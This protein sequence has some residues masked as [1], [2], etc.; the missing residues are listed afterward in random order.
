MDMHTVFSFLYSASLNP[1]LDLGRR[2]LV[3]ELLIV[4]RAVAAGGQPF[5]GRLLRIAPASCERRS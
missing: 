3:G 1:S 2:R 5:A 4:H